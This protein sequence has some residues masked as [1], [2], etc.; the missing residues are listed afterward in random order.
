VDVTEFV[1]NVVDQGHTAGLVTLDVSTAFPT[2]NHHILL[3]KMHS[4]HISADV[5]NWFA[6]YLNGRD[7]YIS[8]ITGKVHFSA[9]GFGVPQG[10]VLGPFLFNLYVNDISRAAMRSQIM[11]YA[12]D[13]TR[14]IKTKR[15]EKR[16][17]QWTP[18]KI[19][20]QPTG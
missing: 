1:C 10:S 20:L 12:D 15:D 17:Q 18:C 14:L 8:D 7:N 16:R 19:G 4:Y 5:V 3:R 2:V 6:S 13:T 9:D 11:Q